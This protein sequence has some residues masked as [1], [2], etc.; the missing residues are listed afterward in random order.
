MPDTAIHIN[1]DLCKECGLCV[2]S[3][4]R[5]VLAGEPGEL[6]RVVAL[7]RCTGCRMCFY[8]CPDF[9]IEVEVQHK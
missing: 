9:A 8:R 4:A 5:D 6:P 3:C 1:H 2:Y 7:E